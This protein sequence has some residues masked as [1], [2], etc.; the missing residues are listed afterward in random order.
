[1]NLSLNSMSERERR[2]THRSGGVAALLL[3]FAVLVPLDKNV[4]AT[5][6]HT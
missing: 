1:M 3:I 2:R 4:A 6:P 5:P